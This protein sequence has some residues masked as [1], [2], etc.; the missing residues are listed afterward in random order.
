M[1]RRPAPGGRAS[2]ARCGSRPLALG[3]RSP[4]GPTRFENRGTLSAAAVAAVIAAGAAGR[5]AS[6]W[7]TRACAAGAARSRTRRL[8][9]AARG[10]GSWDTDRSLS[11]RGAGSRPRERPLGRTRGR[12]QP[13]HRRRRNLAPNEHKSTPFLWETLN[14]HNYARTNVLIVENRVAW[15][16]LRFLLRTIFR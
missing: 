13:T 15:V 16:S 12:S 4:L 14:W 11:E 2:A 8:A 3:E 10:P 5:A 1:T 6:W 7:A 9:R